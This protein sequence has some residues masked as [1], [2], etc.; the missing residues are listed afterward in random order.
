MPKAWRNKE[1]TIMILVK[2]VIRIRIEGK[3]AKT[4]INNKSCK[5]KLYSVP[6]SFTSNT[7]K[8]ATDSAAAEFD[9]IRAGMTKKLRGIAPKN[10]ISFSLVGDRPIRGKKLTF[11]KTL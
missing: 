7:L 10:R 6:S 5:V 3:T 8:A 11:A 9:R 1:S 2:E 4:V